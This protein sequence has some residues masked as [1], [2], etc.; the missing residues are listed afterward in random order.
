VHGIVH[1]EL[2]DYVTARL[3]APV[4][5]ELLVE[6]GVPGKVHLLSETYPDEELTALLTALSR[7]TGDDP[8]DLLTDFGEACVPGLLRTY[9]TFLDPG[10]RTLDVVEH[11]ERVIHRSVRLQLPGADPPRLRTVRPDADEVH[12]LY[13]SPRRLCAFGV[14]VVRGL[15]AHFGE[16]IEIDQSLCMHRGDAHCEIVVRP[17][18]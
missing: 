12:V 15:A 3:G 9:G 7:A 16:S 11:T 6:A 18:R 17:G 8:D 1:A 4:W 14:G 5:S 10:W 2:R 13:A